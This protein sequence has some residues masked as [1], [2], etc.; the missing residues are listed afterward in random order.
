MQ[1]KKKIS[2]LSNNPEELFKMKLNGLVCQGAERNGC[3]NKN[4]KEIKTISF[5]FLWCEYSSA[6]CIKG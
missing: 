3:K 4:I 1:Q 6:G 5:G 2:F